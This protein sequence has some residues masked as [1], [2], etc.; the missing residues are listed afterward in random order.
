MKASKFV[1]RFADKFSRG[2]CLDFVRSV[3]ASE[4]RHREHEVLNG[5]AHF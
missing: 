3:M 1:G 2:L 5:V 4:L